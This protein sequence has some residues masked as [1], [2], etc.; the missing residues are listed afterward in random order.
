MVK[1]TTYVCYWIKWWLTYHITSNI[2][3]PRIQDTSSFWMWVLGK[4]LKRCIFLK[5]KMHI[6]FSMGKKCVKCVSYIWSNTVYKSS[7][8]ATNERLNKGYDHQHPSSIRPTTSVM[9]ITKLNPVTLSNVFC[10]FF[11]LLVYILN[12]IFGIPSDHMVAVH[13]ARKISFYC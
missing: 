12:S 8:C 1:K 7:I 9:A 6:H 3:R 4:K 11:F 5:F 10:N 13:S 2:R